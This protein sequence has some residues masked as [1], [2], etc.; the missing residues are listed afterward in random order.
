MGPRRLALT[1]WI[2]AAVIAGAEVLLALDVRARGVAILPAPAGVEALAPATA[3][4][5]LAR[6][7]AVNM[8]P[9]CWAG[10]LLLMDGLLGPASPARRRPRR[11]A[12]CFLTSVGVWLYFDWINFFFIH[13]WDYHGLEPL[14]PVHVLVAKFVAFGAINPAMFMVAEWYQRLGLRRLR[15]P[16]LALDPAW[17]AL[18]FIAGLGALL[19]P[20]LVRDPVACFAVWV[21]L[22][23]VL[24]PLNLWIG[25]GRAPTLIAD[26]Q[27]GR[28]G[29]T[30]SLM[31][32]GLTCGFLW[33]FWNYWA[34]AKWTYSLAFLG[35][36]ERFKLFEMP[37]LGFAGFA[38]FALECWVAFIGILLA[39]RAV[40]LRVAEP[41]PDDDTVL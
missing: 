20:F 37:L 21:S 16:R 18:L 5:R 10:F 41:L 24:D 17:Q 15:G 2:G 33:E 40:G 19:V 3:L 9:I 30:A 38:P 13:A 29:R 26:W 6:W 31:A 14:G 23:L 36:A 39:L 35:P 4:E 27:A 1:F 12:S 25:R 11:F 28:W 34:A 22:V 7:T 8:T 32:A